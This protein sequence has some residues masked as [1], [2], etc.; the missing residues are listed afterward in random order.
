MNDN[1]VMFIIIFYCKVLLLQY[2]GN[3]KVL[4]QRPSFVEQ[5]IFCLLEFREWIT[6]SNHSHVSAENEINLRARESKMCHKILFS[7]WN[8]IIDLSKYRHYINNIAMKGS[9]LV[10]AGRY[11]GAWR[12]GSIPL[13][14]PRTTY[15]TITQAPCCL[16]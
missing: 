12:G 9:M 15:P 13:P 7:V 3:Y 5:G 1:V 14:L 11:K 6:L 4:N 2:C 8:K 16:S 10:L